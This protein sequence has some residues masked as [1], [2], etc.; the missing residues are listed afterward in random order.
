[1]EIEIETELKIERDRDRGRDRDGERHMV[2]QAKIQGFSTSACW[3][4]GPGIPSGGAGCPGHCRQSSS[5]P[6]LY[7][8]DARSSHPLGVT[9]RNVPRHCRVL[10]GLESPR[11]TA[12]APDNLEGLSISN[13]PRIEKDHFFCLRS[14]PPALLLI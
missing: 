6:E 1:M 3:H 11:S 2:S 13:I 5:I 7:P 10:F 8:H 9:T 12:A 14:L 4:L